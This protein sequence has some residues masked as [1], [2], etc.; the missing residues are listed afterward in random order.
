MVKEQLSQKA[1]EF[2]L[3]RKKYEILKKQLPQVTT[4]SVALGEATAPLVSQI[5]VL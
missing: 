5:E 1:E 3:L 4:A 2:A